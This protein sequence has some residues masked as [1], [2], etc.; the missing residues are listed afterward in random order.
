MGGHAGGAMAAEQVVATARQVFSAYSPKS[1][2]AE[3]VLRNIVNE[4][5]TVIKLTSF[6]SEADPHSTFVGLIMHADRACWAHCGDSRLYHFRAGQLARRS[7]DHSYI[8]YLIKQGYAKE[9]ERKTHPKRNL[10]MTSLGG[11]TQPE[12][13]Y[14]ES[15]PLENNDV[16][17]LCSDGLWAY[18]KDAEMAKLVTEYDPKRAAEFFIDL[19]RARARGGG[20]NLSLAMVRVTV[21]EKKPE[22]KFAPIIPRRTP[23]ASS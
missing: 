15:A 20:D 16:F 10:L 9:E 5:H 22:P 1:D 19:G 17:L 23:G 3:E 7:V 13:T 12:I 18:F 11:D 6:T 8:E 2:S 4:A 21:V 14:G